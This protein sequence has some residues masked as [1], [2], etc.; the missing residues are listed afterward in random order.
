MPQMGAAWGNAVPGLSGPKED[1][2]SLTSDIEQA[3][4]HRSRGD[5]SGQVSQGKAPGRGS[6]LCWQGA[7]W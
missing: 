1:G 6:G 3:L 5:S 2:N 4:H 7:Q